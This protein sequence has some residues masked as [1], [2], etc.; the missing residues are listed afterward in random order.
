MSRIGAI[1]PGRQ[2]SP[3]IE[4]PCSLVDD[5]ALDRQVYD[6]LR[7]IC[8]NGNRLGVYSFLSCIVGCADKSGGAVL[9]RIFGVS[10][11]GTT[12]RGFYRRDDERYKTGIGEAKLVSNRN[13]DLRFSEIVCG[14]GPVKSG[15]G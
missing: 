1:V 12:T 2:E 13:A 11:H 4:T 7:G 10:C 8:R 14:V 9:D 5:F 15:C 6:A 3:G